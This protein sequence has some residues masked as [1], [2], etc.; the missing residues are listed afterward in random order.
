MAYLKDHMTHPE[1]PAFRRQREESRRTENSNIAK[2][3][4]SSIRSSNRDFV[5][6]NMG[7]DSQNCPFSVGA[8]GICQLHAKKTR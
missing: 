4:C 7:T 6:T 1:K 8:A 2:T 3:G 5:P